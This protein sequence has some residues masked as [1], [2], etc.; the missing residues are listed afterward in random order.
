MEAVP[1]AKSKTKRNPVGETQFNI[2][3]DQ[4]FQRMQ[5]PIIIAGS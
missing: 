4:W 2:C 3:F 5:N 1:V